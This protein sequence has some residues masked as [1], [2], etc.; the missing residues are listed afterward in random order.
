MARRAKTTLS[1]LQLGGILAAIAIVAIG[2]FA[3]LRDGGTATNFT[4]TTELDL[5]DYLD[6]SN[7]LSNNT[8]RIQGTVDERLDNWSSSQGRLFSVLAEEGNRQ[9]PL[10]V[11]VP[12]KFNSTNIQRGQRFSFKVTVQAGTG[13]LEVIELTKA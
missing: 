12:S 5:R 4:G 8:Y 11:L 10:P 7:A 6:N 3:L 2:G 13:I 1:P 9:S